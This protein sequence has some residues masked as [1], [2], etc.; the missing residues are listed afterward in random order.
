ML[1]AAQVKLQELVIAKLVRARGGDPSSMLDV[2][3]VATAAGFLSAYV[4]QW[5]KCRNELGRFPTTVQYVEYAS[6]SERQAWR[7]RAQMHEAFPGDELVRVV[8]D[9]AAALRRSRLRKPTPSSLVVT[10]V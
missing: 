3:R 4:I 10:G 7:Q 2:V 5:A 6:I 8:E 9:V 1:V